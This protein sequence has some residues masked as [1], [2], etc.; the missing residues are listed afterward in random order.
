MSL[1]LIKQVKKYVAKINMSSLSKVSLWIVISK[2]EMKIIA[3][4]RKYLG[5]L[6]KV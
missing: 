5:Q 4:I 1:K 3:I 2:E 6:D